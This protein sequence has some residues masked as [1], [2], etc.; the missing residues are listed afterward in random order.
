ME[1]L[2]NR[3]HLPEDITFLNCAYMAPL[4]KTVEEAGLAAV[5]KRRNPLAYSVDDF[6]HDTELIRSE[7]GRLIN[8]D[9]GRIVLIPSVSYGMSNVARNL[10]CKSGQNIVMAAEQFPS[11]FYPWQRAALDHDLELRQ[12]SP[13][14]SAPNREASWNERILEAI[15]SQTCLVALSHTHWADGTRFNLKEVRRKTL[16]VGALLVIDGTQSVGAL[17]MDIAEIQPDALICAGYKWLM[18]P[19]ALGLA[20][21]GPYFDNGRPVEENWINRLHSEDFKGLVNYQEKYQP[22]ALRYEMGEHSNFTLVPMLLAA[23]RE[24]NSFGPEFVQ[25]YTGMLI[26]EAVESLRQ[27]GY[28]IASSADRGNHLFGI[29][30]PDRIDADSLKTRLE[31][32][33]II[34]SWRGDAMR[35]APNVYNT[36]EEVDRLAGVLMEQV[37]IHI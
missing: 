23:L 29:R 16:E 27:T 7:F 13:D 19:Y 20:Y 37:N 1:S 11:N 22:G 2:R 18:G 35:I 17:P 21:Y 4:L 5:M 25:D 24:V 15:D 28:R 10:K 9:P 26:G 32:E 12:V 14:D 33:K 3:F 30:L 6:F 36:R 34:V 8:A 31:Q